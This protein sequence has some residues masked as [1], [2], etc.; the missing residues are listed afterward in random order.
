MD[1]HSRTGDDP[2]ALPA[3]DGPS[4]HAPPPPTTHERTLQDLYD[5]TPILMGVAAIHTDDLTLVTLNPAFAHLFG[6]T[7]AD[8]QGRPLRDLAIGPDNADDILV[9]ARQAWHT[10]MPAQAAISWQSP[11]GMRWIHVTIAPILAPGMPPRCSIMGMDITTH[12]SAPPHGVVQQRDLA[13]RLAAATLLEE[14]LPICLD[15]ALH[16]QMD[17]GGIYLIDPASGDLKLA[18]ARGFSPTCV[19]ATRAAAAES[20]RVRMVMDG[21]PRYLEYDRIM[22]CDQAKADEDIRALA[23]LPL[24]YQGRVIGCFT[25]GSHRNTAAEVSPAARAALEAIVVQVSYVIVRLQAEAALRTSE[26]RL[27]TILQTALDG[28]LVLDRQMRIIEVNDVYCAM[29]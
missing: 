9:H 19:A 1:S 28:F 6:A 3:A 17:C 27:H 20:D 24:T 16:M 26:S 8:L 11:T 10:G 13:Y 23:V 2:F 25:L 29:S 15:V 21:Q 4:A 7:P 22:Y 14:A 5:H 12:V 18:Y